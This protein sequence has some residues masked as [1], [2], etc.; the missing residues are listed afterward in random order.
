MLFIT[1][2]CAPNAAWTETVLHSLNG[3]DGAAPL[4]GLLA[5]TDAFYGVTLQGDAFNWGALFKL[6]PP[7]NGTDWN[8]SVLH[9]F[10][11]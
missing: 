5:G 1:R 6:T 7:V 9:S 11:T 4:V 2:Q 3:S 8:V 10:N